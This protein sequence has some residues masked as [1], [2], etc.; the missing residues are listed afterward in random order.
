[1]N[2]DR[3]PT[4][5]SVATATAAATPSSRPL[6][7]P[8]PT[9]AVRAAGL[10]AAALMSLLLLGSQFGLASHYAFDG[11]AAAERLASPAGV[12]RA[13][14]GVAQQGPAAVAGVNS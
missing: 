7:V 13:A 1:M 8:R 12:E 4:I 2:A 6:A 10:A 3:T 5:N 11:V 14:V 9:V